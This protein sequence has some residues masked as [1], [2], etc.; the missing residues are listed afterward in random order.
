MHLKTPLAGGGRRGLRVASIARFST[1]EQRRESIAAQHRFNAKT[2][3]DWQV[4]CSSIEEISDEGI[5]GE[6]RDRSGIER[7]HEGIRRHEW[8]LLIAE[9][10][11]RLYRNLQFCTTLVATAVDAGIRVIFINDDIDTANEDWQEDLQDAQLHHC[12]DNKYTRRRIKR[13]IDSLWEMGAAVSSLRPGYERRPTKQATARDGEEGPYYDEI[14]SKWVEPIRRAFVRIARGDP[15]W[16]VANWLTDMKVPK[17]SNSIHDSW[18]DKRV[19]TLIRS[20][21]YRGEE[22]RQKTITKKKLQTGMARQERNDPNKVQRRSMPHLRIVSDRLWRRANQAIDARTKS[23]QKLGSEHPLFGLSRETRT[24]LTRI[25]VC[26]V[27]REL[28]YCIGKGYRCRSAHLKNNGCLCWNRAMANRQL[29]YETISHAVV[30]AILDA[31]SKLEVFLHYIRV[32]VDQNTDLDAR[33]DK[34]CKEIKEVNRQCTKLTDSIVATDG[35]PQVIVQ[36]IQALESRRIELQ[37]ELDEV[38]QQ[39]ETKISPPTRDDLMAAFKSRA[40]ELLTL[41]RESSVFLRRLLKGP[42]RAIPFL[43]FGSKKV[44]MRAAFTL[45]LVQLL[46][47]ELADRLTSDNV[48]TVPEEIREV[49][50]VV[51]L[52]QRPQFVLLS[53]QA[54][55]SRH[56]LKMKVRQVAESLDICLP[57]A[58]RAIAF[59]KRLK[60]AG[61]V[62]PYI[63]VTEAPMSISRWRA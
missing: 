59:A 13:A 8:D 41:T 17:T 22:I 58:K 45:D 23:N 4:K 47:N 46:P 52:F 49:D 7:L 18:T 44:V 56:D 16:S 6:I 48:S 37:E 25:F 3:Q 1:D 40:S 19:I 10:S 55:E 39:L 38:R 12:R 28:M 51:D 24:P 60:A 20:T 42:I 54:Y 57:V 53:Q 50:I 9:D 32:M 63:P 11:S 35:P 43:Q 31:S 15:T 14:D 2:I 33:Q 27:C 30:N 61:L 5:S 21:V 36:R 34:L 62:D 26:D 29:T